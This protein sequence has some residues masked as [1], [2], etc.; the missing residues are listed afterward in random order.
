[1]ELAQ[2]RTFRIL[3]ETLSF[4]RTAE[5]LHLT[6]SAVSYQIKSL[7][8]ELGE[9]LFIRNSRGVRLSP[10][11]RGALGHVER[12]LQE[13]EAMQERIGRRGNPPTGGV[14]VAAATQAFVHLFAPLFQRFITTYPGIDLT[15]RTTGSTDQTVSETLSGAADVGFASMPLYSPALQVTELFDDELVLVVNGSHRLARPRAVGVPDIKSERF[16]LLERG[17]SIRRVTDHFFNRVG[18][19]PDLALESNDIDFIKLMVAQGLG[20]SFLPTWAARDEV[21]AGILAQVAIRGHRLR[22]KVAMI[23]LARFQTSATRVFLRFIL[24]HREELQSAASMLR[25]TVEGSRKRGRA[26]SVH[27]ATPSSR[28]Q[29]T[30]R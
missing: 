12:I 10:G 25:T 16:M 18:L 19:K 26:I 13:A 8:A 24:Q 17:S 5:R 7:E 27:P 23:S 22:R 30:E 6:Q 1:M 2:L 14:R 15:F 9:P 3:A 21:T 11:G 29:L 20:I 28:R 4:T